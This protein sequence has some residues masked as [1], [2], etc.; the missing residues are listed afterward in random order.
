MVRLFLRKYNSGCCAALTGLPLRLPSDN[1]RI[2]ELRP[3]TPLPAGDRRWSAPS[4]RLTT[5]HFGRVTG[6][7]VP[8]MQDSCHRVPD[9]EAET[10]GT[11]MGAIRM[12]TGSD[13]GFTACK[14]GFREFRLRFSPSV[15]CINVPPPFLRCTVLM[16]TI[17]TGA[18]LMVQWEL[19]DCW[20]IR[21]GEL[22][23]RAPGCIAVVSCVGSIVSIAVSLKAAVVPG[24]LVLLFAPS[25]ASCVFEDGIM[26]LYDSC[27][28]DLRSERI[29]EHPAGATSS[30][31]VGRDFTC[32][33]P[34]SSVAVVVCG[35]LFI[36]LA[37]VSLLVRP[38]ISTCPLRN[39][40]PPIPM[41]VG[42]RMSRAM[43]LGLTGH[44]DRVQTC[45]WVLAL[46]FYFVFRRR[47]VVFLHRSSLKEVVLMGLLIRACI[48]VPEVSFFRIFGCS[49]LPIPV[50]NSS[51]IF[52][53]NLRFDFMSR[54]P[55]IQKF[56]FMLDDDPTVRGGLQRRFMRL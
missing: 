41:V 46:L 29:R 19:V 52:K 40:F 13:G 37:S 42:D 23:E 45:R 21:F 22:C 34:S 16:Y 32:S 10:N 11:G 1:V 26:T 54:A 51:L 8:S 9:L 15:I 4:F 31:H 44:G 7:L 30:V 56:G 27:L 38:H 14:S 35:L 55:Y 39:D 47:S 2:P 50:S 53:M 3:P 20:V 43:R 33:F 12:A 48:R 28:H 36:L 25:V 18:I 17:R 24:S 49:S 6:V 5:Q